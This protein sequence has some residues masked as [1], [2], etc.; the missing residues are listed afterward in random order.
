M[1]N[2]EII[3]NGTN[4][5]LVL[6]GELC[7]QN[8]AEVFR[9]YAEVLENHNDINV[10]HK[11]VEEADISYYQ[12]MIAAYNSASSKDKKITFKNLNEKK[13]LEL[14]ESLGEQSLQAKSI[15]LS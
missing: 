9:I 10:E 4:A 13:F 5:T 8:S 6:S 15:L 2:Y 12:L 1:L 14:F 7:I 3:E 11:N